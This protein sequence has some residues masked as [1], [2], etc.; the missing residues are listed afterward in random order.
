MVKSENCQYLTNVLHY[1]ILL[2]NPLKRQ[3]CMYAT[4]ISI[5]KFTV[6]NKSELKDYC[7]PFYCDDEIPNLCL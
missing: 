6:K 2:E 7:S 1:I 3:N 5:Q 4:D